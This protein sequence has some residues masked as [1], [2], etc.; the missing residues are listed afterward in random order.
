M[1]ELMILLVGLSVILFIFWFAE[2]LFWALLI[3]IPIWTLIRCV[4]K[5]S[6]IK[7]Q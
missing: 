7:K 6:S 4:K 1:L 5:N 3:I 2:K